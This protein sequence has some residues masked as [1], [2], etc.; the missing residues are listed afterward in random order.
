MSNYLQGAQG[1]YLLSHPLAVAVEMGGLPGLWSCR[2]EFPQ[3]RKNGI[4]A[5][6]M[7]KILIGL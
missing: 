3:E 7:G 4:S 2:R 6:T 5:L 1:H